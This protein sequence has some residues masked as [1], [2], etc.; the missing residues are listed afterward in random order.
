[1]AVAS[2]YPFWGGLIILNNWLWNN[3]RYNKTFRGFAKALIVSII[4]KIKKK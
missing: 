1:M 4:L 2:V 3:I